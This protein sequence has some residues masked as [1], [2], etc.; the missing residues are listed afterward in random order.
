MNQIDKYV[1]G[2]LDFAN[3]GNE[4][5]RLQK[6]QLLSIEKINIK[7]DRMLYKSND[8]FYL[9]GVKSLGLSTIY[10]IFYTLSF[11]FIIKKNLTL[12]FLF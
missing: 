2:R 11:Y 6:A 12:N 8:S 10:F 7:S 3:F 4:V 1:W 5:I 9:P